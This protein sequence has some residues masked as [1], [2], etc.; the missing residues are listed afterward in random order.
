M[1]FVENDG[2]VTITK[3]R[4]LRR[5]QVFYYEEEYYLYTGIVGNVP[6][7]C[8]NLMRNQYCRLCGNETVEAYDSATLTI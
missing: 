4:N 5:G 6:I 2:D 8:Y 3:F 1:K 7:N